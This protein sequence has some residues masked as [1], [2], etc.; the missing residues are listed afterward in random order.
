MYGMYRVPIDFPS[1]VTFQL[2]GDIAL[3]GTFSAIREQA[4]RDSQ[5][6]KTI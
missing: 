3:L 6:H 5:I 1:D 2:L 4:Y